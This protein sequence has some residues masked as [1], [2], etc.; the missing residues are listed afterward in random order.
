MGLDQRL[1]E[2]SMLQR[3]E[4]QFKAPSWTREEHMERN[5]PQTEL[6]RCRDSSARVKPCQRVR[7]AEICHRICEKLSR[8]LAR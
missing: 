7:F 1:F 8:I 5:V 2:Q 3:I 4:L 6:R